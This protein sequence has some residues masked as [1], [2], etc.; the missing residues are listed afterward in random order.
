MFL[1]QCSYESG[2]LSRKHEVKP[3]GDVNVKVKSEISHES[4]VRCSLVN[5]SNFPIQVSYGA[6]AAAR[7]FQKISDSRP[8]CIS[9]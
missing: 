9:I 8:P 6:E 2:K 5:E 1:L 7:L 3:I 4:M